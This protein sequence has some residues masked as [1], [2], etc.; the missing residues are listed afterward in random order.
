MRFQVGT[1]SK[2]VV[3]MAGLGV[4]LPMAA[5]CPT[6]RYVVTGKVQIPSGFKANTGRVYLFMEDD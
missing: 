1:V 3:L 2:A 5:K 4:V 6:L